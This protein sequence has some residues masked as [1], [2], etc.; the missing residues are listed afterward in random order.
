VGA[1]K[2][3]TTN[4][5]ISGVKSG[6]FQPFERTIWQRNY[7]ERILRNE[8][9]VKSIREYVLSNPWKWETDELFLHQA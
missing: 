2:S 7:W 1:F 5:C 8:N 4:A 9:E 3:L 6:K